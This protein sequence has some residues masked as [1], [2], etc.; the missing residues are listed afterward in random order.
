MQRESIPLNE[1]HLP[2]FATWEPGWLLLTAGENRPGGFNSMTVSWG[3][4]GVIWHRPLAIVV[5]RPQRY[6]RQFIDHCD[7]FS[8]C[9]F[10]PEHRPALEMLGTRSGRDTPKMAECG[11]T[12]IPL[13]TIPCPGFAEARLILEC[14]KTYFA[15]LNPANFL[16]DFIAPN[17]QDDYHR[18]YFGEVVAAGGTPDYR[19]VP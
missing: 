5:V 1:L 19:A 17:Y 2:T 12:P 3:A 14:R 9:A 13:T 6:T 16:A 18:I 15:D 10:G 8:L 7:T 11:L 4:L